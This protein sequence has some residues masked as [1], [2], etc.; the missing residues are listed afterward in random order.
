MKR[1]KNDYF[2]EVETNLTKRKEH[3]TKGFNP[4]KSV[5]RNTIFLVRFL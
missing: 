3:Y 1:E 5:S 4:P 2:D